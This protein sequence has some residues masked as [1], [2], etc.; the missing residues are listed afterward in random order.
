MS[1]PQANKR[2]P[3][4]FYELMF[5]ANRPREAQERYTGTDY[6]Q[7]NPGV[8]D[9]KEAFIGGRNPSGGA[10]TPRA[11]R[12]EEQPRWASRDHPDDSLVG[13]ID[14]SPRSGCRRTALMSARG[15]CPLSGAARIEK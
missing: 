4:D 3:I 6:R 10:S 15:A 13:S 5:D 14:I 9:G 2:A 12:V 1:D 8:G 7:R 11:R